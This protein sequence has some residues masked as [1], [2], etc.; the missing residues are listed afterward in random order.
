MKFNSI[1]NFSASVM[2]AL[3]R[4]QALRNG[5]MQGSLDVSNGTTTSMN[6]IPASALPGKNVTKFGMIVYPGFEPFD[7][8]GPLNALQTLSRMEKISLS[9]LS[10][11]LSPVSSVVPGG[12]PQNSSFGGIRI[13][14]T[15]TYATAPEVEALLV[16]GGYGNRDPAII[17]T[18]VDFIKAVYPSVKY[19]I[20][21]CTG[22]LVAAEA[23]VLDGK[24]ATT[25]KLQMLNGWEE[26]VAKGP[27]VDWQRDARWV[28][29]GN[30]WTSSGV[31]AGIDVT[32]AWIEATRGNGTAE[33]VAEIMEYTRHLDKD[34]DPFAVQLGDKTA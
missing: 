11:T 26:V 12:N 25:N 34:K 29:D 6:D 1:I 2:M 17:R 23:G 21:V 5:T 28:V 33:Q 3:A 20:T 8:F 31:S 7:V 22:S 24:K 13:L 18:T 9:I 14:P 16:P 4:P 15:D 32:L 19:L 10:E 30:I 27:K